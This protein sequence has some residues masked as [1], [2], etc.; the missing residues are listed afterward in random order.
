MFERE[1]FAFLLFFEQP[2][3]HESK[4][5]LTQMAEELHSK[6]GKSMDGM[7]KPVSGA[8]QAIVYV[9]NNLA[10]SMAEFCKTY[11]P[12]VSDSVST[13]T[14]L[15]REN[16]SKT[17]FYGEP[18]MNI[19]SIDRNENS[20]VLFNQHD[21]SSDQY[22]RHSPTNNGS[23]SSTPSKPIFG[24]FGI[25]SKPK[26]TVD[27]KLLSSPSSYSNII[28]CRHELATHLPL[29]VNLALDDVFNEIGCITCHDNTMT[30][31]LV[32][33]TDP[34]SVYIDSGASK[35]IEL[36]TFLPQGWVYGRASGG[37]ELYI[38]LDTSMF[39]TIN[40][41]QKAVTRIRERVFNDK[42]R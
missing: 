31:S 27:G 6:T 32:G 10:E 11:S 2:S 40:D 8:T 7:S 39:V 15:V 33:G 26:D 1:E 28:D 42:I 19:I 20:F 41:V 18:G 22:K 12:Y 3:S 14:A 25:G 17:I 5:S 35:S 13:G 9:L 21:L 4:S 37:V 30:S 16:D 36:C 24:L 38:V 29:D 34:N 23:A